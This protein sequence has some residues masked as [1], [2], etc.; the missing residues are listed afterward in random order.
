MV[1]ARSVSP[2]HR[3]DQVVDR[4]ERLLAAD[5]GDEVHRDVL[6]VQVGLGV[7]DERLDGAGAPGE[8]RIG[9]DRDRRLVALTRHD[10]AH[11]RAVAEHG[12]PRGVHAVGGDRRIHRRRDVGGRKAQ[13][14]AAAVAADHHTLD[15]VRA[16]QRLGG[17]HDVT[18]VDAG[19][20]VGRREG[21]GLVLVVLGDQRHA[22]DRE[23]EPLARLAQQV[24]RCP[25]PSCR[26]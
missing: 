23:P 9:A 7:E 5:T 21:D 10:G 1:R 18:G 6:S 13:H 14:L 24:R 20:D 4:A 3:R 2:A 19:S 22:L 16:A 8:R 12:E 15:A 11:H 17:R 25:P 26:R